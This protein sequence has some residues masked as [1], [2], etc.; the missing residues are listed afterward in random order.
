MDTTYG[1]AVALAVPVFLILIAIEIAVDVYRRTRYYRLPDA[2]NSLS[3]GIVSTGMRVFFGFLA[4]YTYEWTLNHA[5]LVHL[6]A[7]HWGTWVFAFI[8]YDLCYYWNNSLIL[9]T[10][11]LSATY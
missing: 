7:A 5:A 3:C 2:I 11:L 6:P 1:K 8:L 4:I 10:P 9:L